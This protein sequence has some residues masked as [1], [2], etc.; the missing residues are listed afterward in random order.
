[1]LWAIKRPGTFRCRAYSRLQ[2]FSCVQTEFPQP[3]PQCLPL[4][5]ALVSPAFTSHFRGASYS[6][7]VCF[8]PGFSCTHTTCPSCY[9]Q[10]LPVPFTRFLLCSTSRV[11]EASPQCC[12]RISGATLP[13]RMPETMN[14]RKGPS[15]SP[16]RT[17]M[18]AS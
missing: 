14:T 13:Y 2:G 5:S 11:R 12:H 15:S 4:C 17:R 7:T 18:T 1:M 6:V 16:L 9:L 8:C 3:F 10:C